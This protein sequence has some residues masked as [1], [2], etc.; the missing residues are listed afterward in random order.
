MK[1]ENNFDWLLFGNSEL[2]FF[3][4]GKMTKKEFVS[5]YETVLVQVQTY[6]SSF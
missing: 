3:G 1:H 2:Q 5:G 6:P 4:N